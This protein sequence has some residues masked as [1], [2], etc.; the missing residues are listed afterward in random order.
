VITPREAFFADQEYIPLDQ[1]IGAISSEIVTVYPPGIPVLV[2]GEIVT[3]E[4]VTYLKRTLT[5]GGT[6]DGLDE[7]NSW[8]GVVKR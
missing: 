1:S 3:G 4:A 5:L 2:P 7:T 8:I 6:V